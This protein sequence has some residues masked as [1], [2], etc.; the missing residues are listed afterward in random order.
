MSVLLVFCLWIGAA[1][2]ACPDHSDMG[3]VRAQ[4]CAIAEAWVRAWLPP[5]G[6]FYV[7]SCEAER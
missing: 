3:E 4:S 1:E 5:G 7:I 2:P 6:Q